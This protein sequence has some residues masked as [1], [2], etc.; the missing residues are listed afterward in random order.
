MAGIL[1]GL[2]GIGGGA[3][4]VPSL[5]FLLPLFGVNSSEVATTAIATS[6][7]AGSFASASSFFN[8]NKKNNLD[9]QKGIILTFGVIISAWYAPDVIVILNP[10]ILKIIISFFLLLVAIKLFFGNS[11]ND[12]TDNK[13]GKLWLFPAGL[14]FGGI[15]AIS[16]LGGG[17]F[18]V[19]ILLYFL[20]GNLKLAV[21][22]STMVVFFTMVISTISF[23]YLN[24]DWNAS[25]WQ[26][27]YLNIP[28]A[29]LLGIGAVV[30]AYLG[31]KLIFK[32]RIIAFKKIFSV[33]LFFIVIKILLSVNL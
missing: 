25:L 29:L 23:A 1:S 24:N 31:V 9:I 8:H 3:V 19:P 27:G 28:A 5:L 21:G 15:A 14:F 20:N 18:Y 2:L 7:F 16:G 6:L 12:K 4:F 26:W 30:G 32:V 17:V 33:F 22:T 13:I 11:A 10:S